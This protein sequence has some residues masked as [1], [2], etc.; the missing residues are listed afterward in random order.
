MPSG[1]KRCFIPWCTRTISPRLLMCRAHWGRV[2]EPLQFDVYRTF[3]NMRKEPNA[4]RLAVFKA[5]LALAGQEPEQTDFVQ[6]TITEIRS[7]IARLEAQAP[8]GK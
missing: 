4:Y 3:R 5:T 8:C 7:E 2:P 6:A 1:L